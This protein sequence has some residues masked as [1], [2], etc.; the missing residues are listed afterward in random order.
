MSEKD[1]RYYVRQVVE[2]LMYIHSK[3]ILHREYTQPY[4]ASN[5]AIFI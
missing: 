5:F 2:A 3:N 4:L 1:I